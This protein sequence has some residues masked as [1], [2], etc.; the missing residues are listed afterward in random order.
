MPGSF[1]INNPKQVAGRPVSAGA[2]NAGSSLSERLSRMRTGKGFRQTSID[3]IPLID[4]DSA[5]GLRFAM[6]PVGGIPAITGFTPQSADCEL[7]LFDGTDLI[8]AGV[9]A[10]IFNWTPHATGGNKFILYGEIDGAL[11][12]VSEACP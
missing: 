7:Y 10:T 2:I 5:R 4:A 8:D 6:T 3:G 11:F 9:T 1:G 12:L